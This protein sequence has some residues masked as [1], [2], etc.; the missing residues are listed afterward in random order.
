MNSAAGAEGLV[1]LSGWQS[2]ETYSRS[3]FAA[4][5]GSNEWTTNQKIAFVTAFRKKY[6]KA[7]LRQIA[8]V[9]LTR[10]ATYG[11][12]DTIYINIFLFLWLLLSRYRYHFPTGTVVRVVRAT[13]NAK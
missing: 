11:E 6:K 8:V 4:A 10:L 3:Q 2:K 9:G 5:A 13:R 12:D 7:Q 1:G